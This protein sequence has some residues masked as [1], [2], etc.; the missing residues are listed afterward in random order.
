[1]LPSSERKRDQTRLIV[2]HVLKD[3]PEP[4]T[5]CDL[6][7]LYRGL[8][9]FN[10]PFH[11]VLLP[12][13]E[14]DDGRDITSVGGYLLDTL[15]IAVLCGDGPSYTQQNNLEELIAALLRDFTSSAKPE[16]QTI[17]EER[18]PIKAIA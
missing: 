14:I 10:S 13:G 4:V 17:E 16:V 8:G 2:V 9:F 1:M 6:V 15:D 3:I 11:F 7:D 18:F 12:N 5:G